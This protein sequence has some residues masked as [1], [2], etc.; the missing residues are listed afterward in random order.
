MK[1]VK[2]FKDLVSEG[3]EVKESDPGVYLLSGFISIP[4]QVVVIKKLKDRAPRPL[5]IMVPEADEEEIRAFLKEV[6]AMESPED[7]N[8]ARAVLNIS[9]EANEQ[10]FGK[11]RGDDEMSEAMKRI[12]KDDIE[13]EKQNTKVIDIKNLMET[14][15]LTLEQAMDALKIPSDERAMYAGMVN[16]K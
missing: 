13:Q 8:N 16:G 14:L 1:P 15:K 11:I 6:L 2:L 10:T 5:R 9:S 7:I 3:C 12:M 4:I